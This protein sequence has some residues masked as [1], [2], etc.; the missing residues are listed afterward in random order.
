MRTMP[1][2]TVTPH[3]MKSVVDIDAMTS[4]N[5]PLPGLQM[6]VISRALEQLPQ[7]KINKLRW[8]ALEGASVAAPGDPNAPAPALE[9]P[10]AG[11]FPPP[12][13]LLGLPDKTAQVVLLE[14]ELQPFDGD[15]RRAIDAVNE[16]VARLNANANVHA[17][18]TLEPIDTRPSVKLQSRT[19]V[20]ASELQALF[21]LKVTWKP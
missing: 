21:A 10:P 16:L 17:E 11:D 1:A 15:W 6:A 8:D 19:G 12:P 7:I 4:R 20:E 13:A 3:N 2:T 18:V 5:V 14:G 9:A